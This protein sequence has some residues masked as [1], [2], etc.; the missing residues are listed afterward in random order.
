M[1]V[2]S[3]TKIALTGAALAS[4]VATVMAAPATPSGAPA[5]RASWRITASV[6]RRRH[7]VGST[8]VATGSA[9]AR[10]RT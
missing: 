5:G 1:N 10:G 6:T 3:I 8:G 2:Q 9:R 4:L 7:S